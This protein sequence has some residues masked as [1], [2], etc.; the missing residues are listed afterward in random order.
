MDVYR[1]DDA[2][3]LFAALAASREGLRAW[4]PRAATLPRD[5]AGVREVILELARR[6]GH[7]HPEGYDLGLF[8]HAAPRQVLGG[9][10]FFALDAEGHQAEVGYWLRDDRQGEGL[11]TE[12]VGR[13]IT[14]GF[15]DWGF[16][17]LLVGT[18]PENAAS[19]R[20][21]ERLGLRLEVR[22]IGSRWTPGHGWRDH[23]GF[24]VLADEWDGERHR[25]PAA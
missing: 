9:T 17:R 24:A 4:T 25:G 3:A 1:E 5:E 11:C 2:G 16:R 6:R 23:V 21:A 12:A 22:E 8:D 20:V 14:S 19:V 13:L 15:A 7:A 18:D 10:G